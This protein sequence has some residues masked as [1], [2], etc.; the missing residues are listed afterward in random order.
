[1]TL[2]EFFKD[3][4]MAGGRLVKECYVEGRGGGGG[5]KARY[6]ISD[7]AFRVGSMS[8]RVNIIPGWGVG[9]I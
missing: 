4:R 9:K 7:A 1:M 5:G 2:T 6:A 8:Q 3:C